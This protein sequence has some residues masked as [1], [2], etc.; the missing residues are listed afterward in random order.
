V[1]LEDHLIPHMKS[2]TKEGIEEEEILEGVPPVE[3]AVEDRQR[4]EES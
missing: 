1:G 2:Q 3:E 4:E